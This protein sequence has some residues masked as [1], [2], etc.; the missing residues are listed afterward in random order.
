MSE[1]PEA[2]SAER[3]WAQARFHDYLLHR[4]G[5]EDGERMIDAVVQIP[6]VADEL[7]SAEEGLIQ[8]WLDRR[9]SPD[10]LE[11]FQRYYVNG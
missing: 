7:D 2:D 3:Q 5:E 6:G 8:L 10:D 11:A 1:L 9:I 4:L